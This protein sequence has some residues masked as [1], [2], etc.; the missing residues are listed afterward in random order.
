MADTASSGGTTRES[1]GGTGTC[2]VSHG[3][4]RLEGETVEGNTKREAHARHQR[5]EPG[6]WAWIFSHRQSRTTE[7][8]SEGNV[9]SSRNELRKASGEPRQRFYIIRVSASSVFVGKN[10]G[11][12]VRI[13]DRFPPIMAMYKLEKVSSS[14]RASVSSCMKWF[15]K[16][17][18]GV[19][20]LQQ[21]V[22]TT[23]CGLSHFSSVRRFATPW[24]VAR[25]A[26][27]SMAF[28]RLEYWSGLPCLPPGDLPHP[29]IEPMSLTSPALAGEFFT[30]SPT[31]DSA[32]GINPGLQTA[33]WSHAHGDHSDLHF[34][35]TRRACSPVSCLRLKGCESALP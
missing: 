3:Q 14:L 12:W 28:S 18:Q 34:P 22:C 19:V 20:R 27:L 25:Q 30:T 13:L 7:T 11:F 26:P 17:P 15:K 31:W 6:T 10:R 32:V 4:M 8:V 35:A 21:C 16:R 29:G 24:T 1:Q 9:L 33:S 23:Y 5:S 2:E